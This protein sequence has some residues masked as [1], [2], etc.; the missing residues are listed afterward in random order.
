MSPI[1]TILPWMTAPHGALALAIN[2][3]VTTLVV[4]SG[5][6]AAAAEAAGHPLDALSSLEY[7]AV[8]AA[9]KRAGRVNDASRFPLIT[10]REPDKS[11]VLQWKVG[12][13]L[14]RRAF[15][16]VKNGRETF[17]AVI[18]L[19]TSR[20]TS[21]QPVVDIEP[22]V[23]L[24][25]W[26]A[27]QE[28]VRSNPGWQA[29]VR[30][31]GID[32]F[33][34]V[35]C[36]PLT[37]GYF[38]IA[39]DQGRRLVK[40]VSFD[41]RGTKNYWGRPIEGLTAVVDLNTREVVKL[42]DTG[43][44]PVPDGPV[45]FDEAS[46]GAPREPP[47]PI[48]IAQS[49]GP[50]FNL[51]GHVVGWQKWSFH[52]RIDPRLGPVI[53]LVRYNDNG[54]MRSILYQGALSELFVPYMD[55]GEG[56]YFRTYLDAGEYGVGRLAVPL[57]PGLDCPPNAVFFDAV[58]ADDL[59]VSYTQQR[60]ACLF[61]RY[62]GDVAWR[63]YEA[64][65]GQSEVRRRTE[66]V[67]RF[68]CAVGNYDYIFDWVFR[69]DGSIQIAVGASGIEQVKAVRSRTTT[70]DEHGR[71]L[72]YGHMV[73]EHTVGINHDH[74]FCFRIDLDV[75]GPR[76]SFVREQLTTKRLGPQSPRRSIWVIDAQTAVH[77]QEARLRINLAKPALWR[78]YNPNSL[79][80]LGYP[81]SYQLKPKGN[82]VSLLSPE[83]FPQ[84]RAGFTDFHLWVTPYREG[85]RYA[86]GTY[87]N[88]S[89]GGDGLPRWTSANR[90]I[91]TTDIV[92]WYTLGFHHVVRAEDWPVLPTGW[93]Q[94]ELRPFDFF[95][96]NPAL[97]LP[98]E[99]R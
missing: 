71:D 65:N 37:V 87:P 16:I 1:R 43:V 53:S 66:L 13:A 3:A 61:E 47:N 42:I 17:E 97:D 28:L 78:V 52:F 24:E 93:S 11:K 15:A 59:G 27:A 80:P 82:A 55:P 50:S 44:V 86:A 38:G 49:Q 73:A 76:N 95:E 90:P 64:V 30:K 56:W 19:S 4:G 14:P 26:T 25:E 12:K 84:R 67:L 98:R 7:S 31:R 36:V 18:D 45:D 9:L 92:L 40:V 81:V 68:V 58:F 88:Q 57:E 21:W 99:S 83:D 34:E 48:S 35:V 70:D 69:Q 62:S 5:G 29:A 51:R 60:A 85:E 23:L 32:D 96:R 63:H 10:I 72:A 89:K 91:E 75:D 39:Q 8:I 94:F 20:V 33:D 54:R 46:V 6:R 22:N 77:E 41:S 79:G 2:L 74:F